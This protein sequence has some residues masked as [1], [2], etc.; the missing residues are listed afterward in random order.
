MHDA[1]RR[2]IFAWRRRFIYWA[3]KSPAEICLP[4]E[5]E[6]SMTAT[7]FSEIPYKAR[8]SAN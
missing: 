3:L 8:C 7:I 5:L 2:N 4:A 1:A 6:G